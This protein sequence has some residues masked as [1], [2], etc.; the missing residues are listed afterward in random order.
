MRMR[1]AVQ[2]ASDEPEQLRSND[3]SSLSLSLAANQA[4]NLASQ[5]ILP[6]M[7]KAAAAAA[8]TNSTRIK[9]LKKGSNTYIVRK[10][11]RNSNLVQ[12]LINQQLLHQLLAVKRQ[13]E[14]P[15][16]AS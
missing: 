10:G 5:V 12:L 6:M 14:Q 16:V 15:E 13:K 4:T 11:Q 7:P 1:A 2:P 3:P 8:A 9:G